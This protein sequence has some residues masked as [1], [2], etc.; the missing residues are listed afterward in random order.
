[1]TST[2]KSGKYYFSVKYNDNNYYL[3]LS[4][5]KLFSTKRLLRKIW[6]IQ[7]DIFRKIKRQLKEII[8]L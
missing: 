7:P 6:K 4:Q 3:I 8:E 5:I 1:M 2:R